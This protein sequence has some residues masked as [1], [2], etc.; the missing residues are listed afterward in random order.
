MPKRK[1]KR[2]CLHC[3]T[4]FHPDYRN[5]RHQTYCSMPECRK[6]SKHASQRRWVAKP[7]NCGYFKGSAN[8]QRVQ[9]WRA[10]NPGYWRPKPPSV[11]LQDDCSLQVDGIKEV[12]ADL[13][14]ETP[15]LQDSYS[16]Q[17]SVFIGFISQLTGIALQ[18]DID[19]KLRAWQKTGMDII[20]GSPLE[21]GECQDEKMPAL[22]KSFASN[23]QAIQLGGSPSGP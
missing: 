23:S 15:P 16:L 6:A 19:K 20:N 21:K 11:A 13:N 3:R 17:R 1:R 4:F 8:V 14:E 18:G 12:S 2:K 5:R 10:M 22:P 7:E 9:E